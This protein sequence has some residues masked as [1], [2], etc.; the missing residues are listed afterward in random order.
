LPDSNN[1]LVA[2]NLQV[3]PLAL[4]TA[5]V[6]VCI[7]A[8][9]AP[10]FSLEGIHYAICNEEDLKKLEKQMMCSAIPSPG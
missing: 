3:R 2:Q 5:I 7:K 4:E 8:R 10:L 6:T 1:G 9:I